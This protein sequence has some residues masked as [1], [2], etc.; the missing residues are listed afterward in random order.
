MRKRHCWLSSDD[1]FILDTGSMD[2]YCNWRLIDCLTDSVALLLSRH[3]PLNLISKNQW[4]LR[5]YSLHWT[6]VKHS[7]LSLYLGTVWLMDNLSEL[8][9]YYV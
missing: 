9:M 7:T 5:F 4:R 3:T 2:W 6:P 8:T 1:V